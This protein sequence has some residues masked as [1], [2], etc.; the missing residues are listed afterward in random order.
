LRNR[1]STLLE[2]EG[3]YALEAAWTHAPIITIATPRDALVCRP[4]DRWQSIEEDPALASF[5]QIPLTESDGQH[6]VAIYIRDQG[7]VPLT[8]EMFMSSG[9]PL[10]AF[11]ETADKQRF[12][13]LVEDGDVVGLVTLSDLQRLPVYSLLFGQLVAVEVL[14]TEWIRRSCGHDQDRWMRCLRPKH[15]ES[16]ERS[17]RDYEQRNIAIDR[18]S[19]A[20]FGQK[21]TASAGLGLFRNRPEKESELRGLRDLRN[22]V[23]HAI[24]LTPSAEHAIE[25]P[26]IARRTRVLAEWLISE[27]E[28]ASQ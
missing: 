9:A 5:D 3:R 16:I 14:L 26:S 4:V 22:R 7:R 28:G 8:S 23:C 2:G 17:W 21:I 24:R 25:I 15:R 19:C 1:A 27:L 12:R 6:I 10:L 11:V 18:L 20:S 13:L